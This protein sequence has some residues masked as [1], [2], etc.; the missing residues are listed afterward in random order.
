MRGRFCL[1]GAPRFTDVQRPLCCE[2]LWEG[3]VAVTLVVVNVV[4][5]EATRPLKR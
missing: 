4:T 5:E 3:V 1:A 2:G